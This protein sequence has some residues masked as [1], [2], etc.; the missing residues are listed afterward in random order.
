[1]W[2]DVIDKDLIIINP[3]VKNK[4]DLFEKMVNHMYNLDYVVNQKKFLNALIEREK[5]ANTELISGIALPHA[6]TDAV[7]KLFV[8]I[9]IIENGIDYDNSKM[10]PAKVIFFFGCNENY[11]KE[12]LK[13]LAKSSRLLKNKGFYQNLLHAKT[14][15]EILKILEQ[16]DEIEGEVSPEKDF[17]L[18]FTL[19]KVDKLSDVLSSMVEVGITNSSIIDATSMAKK[20]AYEMPVFAGLSYMVH[21]KSKQSQVIISYVQNKKIAQNLADLLKE[22]GIDL[23][24]KG[25]GFMQL[26]KI[27]SIIGNYEEEIE[28]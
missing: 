28:L 3:K 21:G 10:G 26:I 13:L 14:P 23:S 18:I 8:S 7:E 19:N 24:Q 15:D 2:K 12:Y 11:N 27:D 5:M 20:L 17:L 4:K 9:V 16:Y 1:M 6:R 22:N 25:T